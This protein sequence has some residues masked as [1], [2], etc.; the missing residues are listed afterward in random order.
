MKKRAVIFLILIVT[1]FLSLPLSSVQG[2]GGV[3]IYLVTPQG[4]GAVAQNVNLQGTIDTSDGKYEVWFGNKLV[5]S[6]NSK[7]YNVNVNFTI[8]ELP[9]GTYTIT[10][11]DATKNVNAT[12][13][14]NI[15]PSYYIKAVEPPSPVLL[16]Q[17]NF[18]VFNVTLTGGQSNTQYYANITVTLPAPLNTSYSKLIMLSST[19]QGTAQAQ[20]TYPTSDF[21]PS[22]AHTNYT[23]AY[24]VYFNETQ[25]LATDQFFVG[26]ISSSEYH[27]DQPV[28]IR[29]IG[30]QPNEAATIKITY[31]K[32]GTDMHTAN[33]VAS[34]EGIISATWTV[35][36]DAPMGEYNITIT[37]ESTAKLVPDSQLF[38][39][40]GYQVMFKTLNLAGEAVPQITVEATDQVLN[41]KIN[42]TSGNDGIAIL[43]LE[44]GNHIVSAFWNGVQVGKINITVTGESSFNLPCELTNLKITVKDNNGNLL[45]FVNIAI[46]YQYTTTKE[47]ISKTGSV[48][49]QTG[50]SGSFILNSTLT[51][52]S[53]T[54]NASLYGI[55][56]NG[57]N[58]TVSTLTPQPISH[59]IIICPSQ[60][61]SVT[62]HD[63]AKAAISNARIEMFESTTGLFYGVTA[64]N[65][66]TATLEVT[67]GRYKARIYTDN[68][69]LYET[70]IDAFSD[71]QR[72]ICCNLCNIQVR[73]IIVDY[74]GQ[75]VPNVNVIL[76][77]VGTESWS[78]TTQA[79]GTAT[80]NNVIGGNMQI[81]AYPADLENVYE[82]L[83]MQI[84][85]PATIQIKMAKYAL[86]GPFLLE[87]SVLATFIIIFVA[88]VLFLIVEVYRKKQQQP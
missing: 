53:Y 47:S 77:G 72:E 25:K 78:A 41:E 17:G 9:G 79:D 64:D 20:L 28:L 58:N 71:T 46:T 52:V 84:N 7:G 54:V 74:F 10:L 66:G 40:P 32:T 8:P 49:G 34:N 80:F 69:L 2:Q 1:G 37:G 30:Y 29:A 15:I 75:P 67:F 18:V 73:V 81:I 61:I 14:F 39:V 21:Q 62:V 88:L 13:N 44:K 51:G 4:Q 5:A 65:A 60:T 68:I 31:T 23:G 27:R 38:T 86:L 36:S 3:N 83:T 45:P 26:F 87:I 12:Q 16:Q 48:S 22:G 6:D 24:Q 42:G 59:V 55:V 82:A 85:E 33:A 70:I 56:F 19:N 57:G 50:L 43:N 63:Y 76:K 11:R 35:P